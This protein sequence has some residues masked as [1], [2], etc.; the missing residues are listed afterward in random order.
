MS[1]LI[2]D[3]QKINE[4]GTEIQHLDDSINCVSSPELQMLYTEKMDEI[5]KDYTELCRLVRQDLEVYLNN[6]KKAGEPIE[7]NYYRLL[8]E[9]RND[10]R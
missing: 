4:L 8:K 10:K 9:L 3:I 7:L 2:Q 5:L 6:Q 1:K